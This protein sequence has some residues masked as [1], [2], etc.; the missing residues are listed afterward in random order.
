MSVELDLHVLVIDVI[1][2]GIYDLGRFALVLVF[3][4]FAKGK[5]CLLD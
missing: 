1:I 3:H 4:H 5:E 2:I